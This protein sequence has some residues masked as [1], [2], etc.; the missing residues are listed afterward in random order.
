M[1]TSDRNRGPIKARCMRPGLPPLPASMAHLPIDARGFPVPY[2]VACVNTIPDHRVMD[3]SK[4]MPAI[5]RRLCWMCGKKLGREVTFTIGPMC[6]ITRTISE[7]PSHHAC[8]TYAVKA[9]PF[10]SRPHAKRREA[11]L[12][13]EAVDSAGVGLKRNPGAT[14]LWTTLDFEVDRLPEGS[15]EG[16]AGILFGLGE[17]IALEWYAE[18]R[19]ATRAE[20][21]ASI[22][23]GIPLLMPSVEAQGPA[24]AM[25]LWRRRSWLTSMLDDE[26]WPA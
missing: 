11:G 25:E 7:P 22:E 6:C 21:D 8:A 19:P 9:C 15:P 26:A 20:V 5:K 12:P 23:S 18:G 16:R 14:C 4:M 17:P 2:F 3:G 10:L 1:S 13:D 24:A